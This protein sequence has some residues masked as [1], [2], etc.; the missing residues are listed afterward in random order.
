MT[1]LVSC[2][3]STVASMSGGSMARRSGADSKPVAKFVRMV[4]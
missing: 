2:T 1:E 3:L 4:E